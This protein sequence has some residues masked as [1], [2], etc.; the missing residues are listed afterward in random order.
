MGSSRS[1]RLL[2]LSLVLLAAGCATQDS[3]PMAPDAAWFDA[4]LAASQYAQAGAALQ[5]WRGQYPQDS[6]LAVFAEKLDA[7]IAQRRDAAIA[8]AQQLRA[9]QRWADADQRL[10]DALQQLPDDAQLKAEYAQFDRMRE[11]QRTLAQHEFDLVYARSLPILQ[12]HA[13][14]VFELKPQDTVA[15]AQLRN[16]EDA[17]NSMVGRLSVAAQRARQRGDMQDALESLRL[18]ARLSG[19]QSLDQ[20]AQQLER[21][22]A[23][24]ARR[25]RQKTQSAPASALAGA[26]AALDD[27]LAKNQLEIAQSQLKALRAKY[28]GN[29]QVEQRAQRF[30]QQR[31]QFVGAALEQGRRYYSAGDLGKAIDTWEAAYLLDPDNQDLRD[32][33]DRAQR[34]RAKVESLQ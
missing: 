27:A 2:L 11:E 5:Q 12:Q 25:P 6:Q 15:A 21:E 9:Q 29:V 26:V 16:L 24:T 33:I 4:Q 22:L 17:V 34:F 10:L 13:R 20:Q 1:L 8:D 23:K 14:A 32:R 7:G 3:V 18:A 30:E 19:E 31:Q 28:P